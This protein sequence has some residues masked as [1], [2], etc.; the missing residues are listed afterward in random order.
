MG[1]RSFWSPT[2]MY[3]TSL[4]HSASAIQKSPGV[5]PRLLS[6]TPGRVKI[7]KAGSFAGVEIRMSENK[8]HISRQ[9]PELTHDL[10]SLVAGL[11]PK[12]KASEGTGTLGPASTA[13]SDP[14]VVNNGTRHAR[15]S[16]NYADRRTPG[17]PHHKQTRS[18]QP[19]LSWL[20]DDEFES[21]GLAFKLARHHMQRMAANKPTGDSG[22]S[23]NANKYAN[24]GSGPRKNDGAARTWGK[25]SDNTNK[26]ASQPK[27]DLTR[28]SQPRRAD[29]TKTTTPRT[30]RSGVSTGPAT[31]YPTLK[32]FS[33]P[34]TPARTAHINLESADFT[35]LF[36]TSP[37]LSAAPS[38]T[39]A[40]TTPT[41]GASR[42][43]QLIL[44]SRGGDYSRLVSGPLVTSQ[45]DPSVYA[46][47]A[48]ARRRELGSNER[49]R[50]LGII[51][52]MIGKSQGSQQIP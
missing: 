25:T 52:G 35:S 28:K 39:S 42:R 21:T 23:K 43:V 40:K 44:E 14:T 10:H 32:P 12:E 50:A 29:T 46:E 47:R 41:D 49:N 4:R 18:S 8:A 20:G 38:S 37:P 16:S 45:G 30:V 7:G 22:P 1:G 15:R 27:N 33:V 24:P 26:R 2:V 17:T 36:G 34:E 5:T 3:S 19:G 9:P 6:T 31:S 51:R 13:P 48:M 11:P